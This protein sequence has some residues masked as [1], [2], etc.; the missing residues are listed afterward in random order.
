MLIQGTAVLAAMVYSGVMSFILLKLIGLVIP[1][2]ASDIRGE[3]KGST[4]S[5]H[6]EEAYMHDRR[7]FGDPSDEKGKAPDVR[8]S[9]RREPTPRDAAASAHGRR[10]ERR[11]AADSSANRRRSRC[12]Y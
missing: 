1:L 5:A 6:G 11:A 4:S 3:R 8:R 10:R 2:R 12:R 7:R 9:R